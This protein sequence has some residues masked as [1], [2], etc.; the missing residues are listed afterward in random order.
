MDMFDVNDASNA[1]NAGDTN[2]FFDDFTAEL[3]GF[4]A[5]LLAQVGVVFSSATGTTW[6][7][8]SPQT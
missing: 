3:N 8:Q 4:S 7:L 2:N 1:L 6:A 5:I